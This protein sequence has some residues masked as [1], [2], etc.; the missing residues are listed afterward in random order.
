MEEMIPAH[1]FIGGIL[2]PA[3]GDAVY[4]KDPRSGCET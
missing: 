3:I 1:K 4:R 2:T